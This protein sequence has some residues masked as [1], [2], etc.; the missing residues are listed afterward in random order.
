[1]GDH[2]EYLRRLGKQNDGWVPVIAI[3]HVGAKRKI[4]HTT[5][6][7][8]RWLHA[9]INLQAEDSLQAL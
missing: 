2:L 3:K 7:I 9:A 6:P 4:F 5:V 8:L 1:M